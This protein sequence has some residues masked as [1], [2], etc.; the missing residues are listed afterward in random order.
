MSEEALKP[1]RK[2]AAK[3]MTRPQDWAPAARAYL[4]GL[5]TL[6]DAEYAGEMRRRA[7]YPDRYPRREK[8]RS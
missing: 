4:F 6:N 7:A 3:A 8:R 2:D 5:Q 1:R